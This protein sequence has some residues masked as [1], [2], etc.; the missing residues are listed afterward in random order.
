MMFWMLCAIPT[1]LMLNIFWVILFRGEF[2]MDRRGRPLPPPPP[3]QR[4]AR[5]EALSSEE[6]RRLAPLVRAFEARLP[7]LERE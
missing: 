5:Q 6:Y 7:L 2:D 4:P 1:I 3:P